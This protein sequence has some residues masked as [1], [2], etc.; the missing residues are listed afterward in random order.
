M[1]L[2]SFTRDREA[3]HGPHHGI[4]L[5]LLSSV[6]HRFQL[7]VGALNPLLLHDGVLTSLSRFCTGNH[8][9]C[10]LARV[11][12]IP[13]P[14]HSSSQHPASLA[15]SPSPFT[16]FLDI[17]EERAVAVDALYTSEHSVLL[18]LSNLGTNACLLSPPPV[19]KKT[20]GAAQIYTCSR[21]LSST[22]T[23]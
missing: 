16:M 22:V 9:D 13:C 2:Q 21:C 14:E 23:T 18:F 5:T 11:M 10:E 7:W 8:N 6:A 17:Q 15:S 1:E 4:K 3:Y 12:V 20:T 19:H